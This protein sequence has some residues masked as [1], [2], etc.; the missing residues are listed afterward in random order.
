M[1]EKS[2]KLGRRDVLKALGL[3]AGA[4]AAPVAATTAA[5]TES[6]SERVKAR[7][8]ESDHVKKFYE[9]NRYPK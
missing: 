7:Y 1:T 2:G 3:G 5:A 4:A 8:K 6:T 9:T